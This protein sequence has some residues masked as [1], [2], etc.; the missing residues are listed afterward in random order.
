MKNNFLKW[1]MLLFAKTHQNH[2]GISL[3]KIIKNN[4]YS[5]RIADVYCYENKYRLNLCLHLFLWTP[6]IYQGLGWYFT[7]LKVAYFLSFKMLN[8]FLSTLKAPVGHLS[9]TR[10]FRFLITMTNFL[11]LSHKSLR[12]INMVTQS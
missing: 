9:L 7:L 2:G 5:F 10:C 12:I 11:Q 3:I 6:S 1:T 4:H 8:P